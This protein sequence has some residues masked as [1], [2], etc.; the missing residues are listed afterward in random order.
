MCVCGRCLVF[1]L[2]GFFC[3]FCF[4]VVVVVVVVFA[5]SLPRSHMAKNKSSITGKLI[6]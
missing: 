1:C 6:G 3:F 5:D 4:V 2:F